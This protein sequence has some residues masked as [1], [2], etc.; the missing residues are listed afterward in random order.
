MATFYSLY[1]P[2]L[3]GVCSRYI[4]DSND[5]KDVLQ[6]AL[7]RIL[8]HVDDFQYQGPG[9]LQAW[10]GRIVAN[11]AVRHLKRRQE[12]VELRPE[13]PD[14]AEEDDPPIADIPPEVIHEM[15][16]QLPT[17]Y[18]TVFNLYVLE[19][20]SHDEIARMLGITPGTSTSQLCRAKNLLAKIIKAYNQQ[21][22]QRR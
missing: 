14:M 2:Y 21:N 3:K 17:G 7:I 18:R 12:L 1:A 4:I 5:V 16:R 11:E 13:L 22:Q 6:E 8:T 19:D 9:S 10:A 20:K 15:I